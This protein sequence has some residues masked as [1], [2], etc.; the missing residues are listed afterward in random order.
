MKG[1]LIAI[2]GT[3]GSG[4]GTQSALL[5]E[6]LRREGHSAELIAFPR[7][8]KPSA[9]F[10]EK[11]LRGEYPPDMTDAFQSAMFYAL[12]RYEAA[13]EISKHLEAGVVMV[14]DRYTASSMA[15]LGG[16]ITDRKKRHEFYRW[17]RQLEH[18]RLGIPK[19]D[20]GVLL[21]MPAE[22]AQQQVDKKAPRLYLGDLTRDI[23]EDDL[24][25]QKQAENA[26]R[27]V[28][29]QDAKLYRLVSC[30]NDG[31]LRSKEAISEEVW[32]VVQDILPG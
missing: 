25:H 15:H 18:G 2:E 7:Y 26:Y 9:Y 13:L 6:R 10:V 32:E 16:K 5:V 29:M 20:R 17:L 21:Y 1:R 30:I 24:M 28:V 22:M 23:H 31:Q 27:E 14:A 3:D 11:Y 8:G 4:K 12:D 19:P